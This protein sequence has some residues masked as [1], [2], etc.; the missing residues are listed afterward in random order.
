M[1]L[2]AISDLHLSLGTNKP[3]DVFGDGWKNYENKMKENWNST[4]NDEDTVLVCGDIS[5]AMYLQESI[6]DFAYINSLPGRKIICKGNHDYWWSTISKQNKFILENNFNNIYF[7]HNNSYTEEDIGIYGTRGWNSW[8][9]CKSAED[10]KIYERELERLELSFKSLP[11]GITK[12]VV[13]LHYPPDDSFREI[14]KNHGTSVCI[15]GHL[16]ANA[17]RYAIKGM[18]DGVLYQLVACDY[19]KFQPMR[20]LV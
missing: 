3:M 15:Y 14:L 19:L 4:I 5:W 8:N 10:K 12:K 6:N 17:G 1:A 9:Q 7:L 13:M 2:Y 20:I 18:I 11:Q 16:H